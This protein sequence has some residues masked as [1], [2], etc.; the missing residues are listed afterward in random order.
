VKSWVLQKQSGSLFSVY[1]ILFLHTIIGN[2]KNEQ[3]I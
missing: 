2:N 3:I 1:M